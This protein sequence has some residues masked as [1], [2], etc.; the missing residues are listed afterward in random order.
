[1]VPTMCSQDDVRQIPECAQVQEPHV[2]DPVYLGGCEV[3]G[4]ES[5]GHDALL[6]QDQ[7][8]AG[9]VRAERGQDNDALPPG[10]DEALDLHAA[11]HGAG[12]ADGRV[13]VTDDHRPDAGVDVAV[14]QPVAHDVHVVHRQDAQVVDDV[15]DVVVVVPAYHHGLGGL[16]QKPHDPADLVLLLEPSPLEV[17]L[18]VPEQDDP[19][20]LVPAEDVV[21]GVAD[22]LGVGAGEV[23]ALLLQG[24]LVAEV[25]VPQDDSGSVVEDEAPV[26]GDAHSR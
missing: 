18:D 23:H 16:R 9:G 12:D 14:L 3:R 13:L 15:L 2:G 17:V 21:E 7:V 22:G 26:A 25:E 6:V 4:L 24:A 19:L 8:V 5:G 1:M 20:R 11:A 10:V